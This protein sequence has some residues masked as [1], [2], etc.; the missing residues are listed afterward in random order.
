VTPAIIFA[1]LAAYLSGSLPFGKW[2]AAS[3]GVDILKEGSGNIGATNVWRVLGPKLGT[4]VLAMDV[5]KGFLPSYL[6]PLTI[7]SSAGNPSWGILFGGC[8][9]VG[10]S[11][12]P[13]LGMK[14]GKGVA[15]ALGVMLAVTPIVAGIAFAI[16]LLAL[17][18]FGFVSLGSIIASISAPILA[19]VF[20]FP[21]VVVTVYSVLAALIVIRHKANIKRLLNGTEPRFRVRRKDDKDA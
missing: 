12:S 18:A 21:S 10:H 2:I 1:C 9:V 5:L 15:T 7:E 6:L 8:A 17:L 19:A 13:F 11:L 20:G 16:F 4:L 3:C 14:G